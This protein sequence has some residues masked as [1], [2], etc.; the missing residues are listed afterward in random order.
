M[1]LLVAAALRTFPLALPQ[2][3]S[4]V[5]GMEPL[6]PEFR[7]KWS[8]CLDWIGQRLLAPNLTSGDERER[9]KA[10]EA[11]GQH[12]ARIKTRP[13]DVDANQRAEK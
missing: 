2:V 5:T 1:L 3:T 8:A 13:Q 12:K 4:L 7:R 6:D 10:D 11:A 9:K